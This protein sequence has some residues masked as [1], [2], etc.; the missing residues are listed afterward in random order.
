MR[1]M[2]DTQHDLPLRGIVGAQ[3][4]RYHDARCAALRLKELAHKPESRP[5]VSMTLNKG[6]ENIAIFIDGTP[7]PILLAVN[8][9]GFTRV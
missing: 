9:L 7:Q 5:F 1:T 4:V 3:L 6:V 8:V 2:L